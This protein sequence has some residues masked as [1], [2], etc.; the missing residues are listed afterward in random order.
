MYMLFSKMYKYSD[1]AGLILL[2]FIFQAVSSVLSGYFF[3]AAE[4][5]V[6]R[7]EKGR[8]VKKYEIYS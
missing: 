3:N 5:A 2:K 1:G 8:F 7:V 6:F 4:I